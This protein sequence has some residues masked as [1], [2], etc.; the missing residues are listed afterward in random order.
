[1][2]PYI[3]IKKEYI[4]RTYSLVSPEQSSKFDFNFYDYFNNV[5][6]EVNGINYYTAEITVK[7]AL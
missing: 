1:M 2:L 7:T 4:C 5:S 3:D 6:S